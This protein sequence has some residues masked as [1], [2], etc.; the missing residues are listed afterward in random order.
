ML[1]FSGLFQSLHLVVLFQSPGH[2]GAALQAW[3]YCFDKGF[4]VYLIDNIPLLLKPGQK[5]IL[6]FPDSQR[7]VG[8]CF[9]RYTLKD[10][11]LF[12]R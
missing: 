10:L 8:R 2:T 1:R 9:Y 12:R 3:R 4:A 11:L 7:A 5:I 6:R